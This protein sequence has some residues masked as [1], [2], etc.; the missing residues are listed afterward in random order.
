MSGSIGAQARLKI[1]LPPGNYPKSLQI[2]QIE[3]KCNVYQQMNEIS[4]RCF[5]KPVN[6]RPH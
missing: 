5:I 4:S 3:L 6:D 1:Y 2:L